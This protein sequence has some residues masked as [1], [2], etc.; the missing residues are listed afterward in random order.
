M[1][2]TQEEECWLQNQIQEVEAA[3]QSVPI[4]EELLEEFTMFSLG[5]PLSKSYLKSVMSLG[6]ERARR[7]FQAQPQFTVL[8]TKYQL[9]ILLQRGLVIMCVFLCK[10]SSFDNGMEQLRYGFSQNDEEIWNRK[11]EA[12]FK[13]KEL[14]TLGLFESSY[15]LPFLLSKEQNRCL[16]KIFEAVPTLLKDPLV[17]GFIL[18]LTLSKPIEGA[19]SMDNL[20][21]L[22]SNYKLLMQRR[23]SS[24]LSKSK[25]KNPQEVI[26]KVS[27]SLTQ[28]EQMAAILQMLAVAQQ[29]CVD[30][31]LSST[32]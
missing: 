6:L 9:D 27:L 25:V 29:S 20:S 17:Y 28:L 23:I 8:P 19:N 3:Y 1:P 18:L 13:K 5:V 21:K 24:S 2:Y 16:Q 32:T 15:E 26:Q 7:M 10:V 14:K 22:N 31:L 12:V 30:I 11:F 4:G